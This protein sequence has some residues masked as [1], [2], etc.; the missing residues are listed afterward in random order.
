[1]LRVLVILAFIGGLI[2]MGGLPFLYWSR[3]S[4]LA[5]GNG[6]FRRCCSGIHLALVPSK[7]HPYR[8]TLEELRREAK[9]LPEKDRGTL[10]AELLATFHPPDYD[11]SDAQVAQRVEELETGAVEDIS[12]EELQSRVDH[13]RR[14]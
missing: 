11:V 8:V 2:S 7:L 9:E 12:L 5:G 10:V 1:M 4:A 6:F 13:A 14:E 3:Y